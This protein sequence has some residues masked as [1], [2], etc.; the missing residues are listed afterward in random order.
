MKKLIFIILAIISLSFIESDEK[1]WVQKAD[2]GGGKIYDAASFVIGNYAY[3]ATGSNDPSYGYGLQRFM[4]RYDSSLDVWK[5]M[6]DLPP[7]AAATFKAVG[8]AIGEKGYVCGGVKNATLWEYDPA[9]NLWYQRINFPR[10][11]EE[12]IGFSISSKA[13]AGLGGASIIDYRNDFYEYD[14]SKNKWSQLN[15]FPGAPR[16]GSIGFSMNGKGY[17]GLGYKDIGSYNKGYF[18]DFWE[19]DPLTDE[20]T[21]LPDF[22]GDG[23]G[24]AIGFGVDGCCYVGMGGINDFY[25]YDVNKREWTSLNYLP[26]S[27]K[28]SAFSFCVGSSI[29]Y[30]GGFTGNMTSEMWEYSTKVPL[31]ITINKKDVSIKSSEGSFATAEVTSNTAWTASSN[32]PWLTINSNLENTGNGS[33]LFIAT[34]NP[35]NN[36]RTATVTISANGAVSQ[37]ISVTQEAGEETSIENFSIEKVKLYPNPAINYFCVEGINESAAKLVLSDLNGKVLFSSNIVEHENISVNSL[38]KGLYIVTV[39]TKKGK[40]ETKLVKE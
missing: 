25:K 30:G 12:G 14:P 33:L 22:P 31:F 10:A 39:T 1:K 4:Y 7:A 20:W 11:I 18:K 21:R 27:S 28:T 13:Y 40:T 34:R 32:Q 8:F 19:Y 15:D 6:A 36:I 38:P 3:V 29:Y 9:T 16:R 17:A 37:T 23:R 2:F 26:G 5:K 35:T 24:T